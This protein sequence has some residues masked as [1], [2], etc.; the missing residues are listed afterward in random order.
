MKFL[1]HCDVLNIGDLRARRIETRFHRERRKSAIMLL[2]VQPLLGYGK[3]DLPVFDNGRRG[4]GMKH[5]QAQNQH[6]RLALFH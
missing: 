4:I 3:E 2:P 6:L 5:I 1:P